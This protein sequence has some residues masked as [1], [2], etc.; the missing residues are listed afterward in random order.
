VDIDNS[1][2]IDL[3]LCEDYLKK[4]SSIK[5]LYVVSFSGLILNQDRLRD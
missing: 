3:D 5:A 4:D 2:L 1:G